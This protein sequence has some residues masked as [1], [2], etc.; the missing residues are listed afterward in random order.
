MILP[1]EQI[2]SSHVFYR[3]EFAREHIHA[4]YSWTLYMYV[5]LM[6]KDD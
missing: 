1:V 4:G 2:T 3:V 5:S 6:F